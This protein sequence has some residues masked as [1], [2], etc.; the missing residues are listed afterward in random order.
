[1]AYYN[2]PDYC[3]E[4][5]MKKQGWSEMEKV[6]Q[7]EKNWD[8]RLHH[9]AKNNR[10]LFRK[11][12]DDW[13]DSFNFPSSGV[14]TMKMLHILKLARENGI[15]SDTITEFARAEE[16]LLHR[17]PGFV[18]PAAVK[19]NVEKK[20]ELCLA[21]LKARAEKRERKVAAILRKTAG[22]TS[23][24][25]FRASVKQRWEEAEKKG[26]QAV[27][28]KVAAEHF[29]GDRAAEAAAKL[30]FEMYL[31]IYVDRINNS[32]MLEKQVTCDM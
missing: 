25:E 11:M 17:I 3:S 26:H 2:N 16:E 7:R 6:E 29:I 27:Q 1:M 20:N 19:F 9:Y 31:D 18:S 22:I 23:A 32:I 21:A 15:L 24:K 8:I 10:V 4:A 5:D 13:A 12:V 14:P 30:V 28:A